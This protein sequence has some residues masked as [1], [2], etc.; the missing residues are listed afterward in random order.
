MILAKMD[1]KKTYYNSIVS[2]LEPKFKFKPRYRA[3][4][5]DTDGNSMRDI[6]ISIAISQVA[7][8]IKKG[9]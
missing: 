7:S 8:S 1:R 3:N 9:P 6:S 4:R 2:Q 5:L